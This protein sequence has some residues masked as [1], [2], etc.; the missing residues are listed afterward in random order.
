MVVIIL[1][2]FTPPIR[3]TFLPKAPFGL[4]RMLL[5]DWISC[6]EGCGGPV[7]KVVL[8]DNHIGLQC[9]VCGRKV[10]EPVRFVDAEYRTIEQ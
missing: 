10:E 1:P 6:P 3:L 5:E 2:T 9:V 4:Y 7:R 8:H